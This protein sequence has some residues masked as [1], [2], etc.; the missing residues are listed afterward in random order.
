VD[1]APGITQRGLSGECPVCEATL[2]LWV[3]I[4]GSEAGNLAVRAVARGGIFVTGGVALKL[5][6]KMTDGRFLAAVR[7][8]EKMGEFLE[9]IPVVIV[10][11]EECPL[12]GAAYVAWKGL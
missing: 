4:Y 3:E 10:L 11:N 5:L 2:D 9:Q 1:P 8:K 12:M 6:P 7:D